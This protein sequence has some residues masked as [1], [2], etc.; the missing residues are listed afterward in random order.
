MADDRAPTRPLRAGGAVAHSAKEPAPGD[1]IG[2]WM[3]GPRLGG[4]G[5]GDVYQARHCST[6]QQA[7]LKLLHAHFTAS[8]EMLARFDR[9]IQVLS[10]LRHPNIVQVVDAGFDHDGRPFLAME[11][12]DG[13]DLG[14]LLE[15]Q[16]RL[17]LDAARAIF[18]PL[19]DAVSVA[20]DLGVVHRDIKA[21]N[22]FVCRS[23]RVV[24]LDF[25]IAKI[26]DA[27]SPELTASHQSLGTPGSMA[28]EQI[29]GGSVNARTDIYALGGLLFHMLTG[30]LAFHDPSE[31]MTQYLHLHARRPLASALAP[32][33]PAVDDVI[34]CA[35]A[36]EAG[37][38]FDD[39]RSL[40]AAVRTALRETPQIA[41]AA[42]SEH[43][44]IFVM[45]DDLS[46]GTQL[47]EALISDLEA[48]LPAAERALSA[49]G[50]SLAL[51]LGT[52]AVFIAPARDT[53]VV[54]QAALGT[55]DQLQRRP[56]QDARVRIGICIHRGLATVAGNR[57]EP[58][59]LLRPDTWGMPEPLEGVWVTNAIEPVARR[60]R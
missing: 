6:H 22:V 54:V 18:E 34:V 50:F 13:Q 44:A 3:I 7:A 25:G 57:V 36:I 26:S 29:Q 38:R 45:I 28:P 5:F 32:V 56:G 41:A 58:C 10:R 8:P 53:P 24:L 31:T 27:L 49:H 15:T 47:D 17:E 39:A 16:H 43:A 14:T 11:L 20:H 23:G 60:L 33:G 37:D 21:S 52:S 19:C 1:R 42:P 2:N 55:W 46:S 35:M 12:L 9:E 59:A 51:D 48:V 40:L 4:G 30:K